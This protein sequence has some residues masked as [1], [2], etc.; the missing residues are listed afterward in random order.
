[1]TSVLLVSDNHGFVSN[2]LDEHIKHADEIWHAGDILTMESIIPFQRKGEVFRAVFGNV[3]GQEIRFSFPEVNIFTVE[4]VKV[5]M[6]HIGGY[7]GKYPDRIRRLLAFENPD[8]FICG[9]SHILKV[10]PDAT[11]NLLHMN[12]GAYGHHG[13]HVVRTVLTFSLDKG[14]ISDVKAIELGIRGRV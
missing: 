6:T 3:D 2:E 13:F 12:P 14:K 10:M 4:D 11:N 5:L 9:H 1:M 7:P 8:L